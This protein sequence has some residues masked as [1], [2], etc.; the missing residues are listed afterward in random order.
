MSKKNLGKVKTSLRVENLE[1]GKPNENFTKTISLKEEEIDTFQ[2]DL[3]RLSG[4]S[5]KNL[6]MLFGQRS[7]GNT[8]GI[9]FKSNTS[10]TNNN[11]F[12]LA[13]SKDDEIFM[14]VKI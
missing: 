3:Q 8:S 9:E 7:F 13:G 2:C 14:V 5:D 12:I 11:T 1:F 4:S 6:A 10:F